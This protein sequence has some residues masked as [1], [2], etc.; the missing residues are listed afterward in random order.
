MSLHNRHLKVLIRVGDQGSRQVAWD[1]CSACF[2]RFQKLLLLAFVEVAPDVEVFEEKLALRAVAANQIQVLLHQNLLVLKMSLAF[3]RE[4]ARVV[5]QDSLHDGTFSGFRLA[6][7]LA[8]EC[9]RVPRF[10]V[11][12]GLSRHAV[13]KQARKLKNVLLCRPLLS[14]GFLEPSY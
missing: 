12:A 1:G 2:E 7:W 5:G 14:S 11:L 8:L 4:Q 6:D 3:P 13:L 9:A 10:L